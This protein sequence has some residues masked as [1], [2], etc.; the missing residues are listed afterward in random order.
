MYCLGNSGFTSTYNNQ[1]RHYCFLINQR[2]DSTIQNI[3]F[4]SL[5]LAILN[6][7][8]AN[9]CIQIYNIYS[10]P[11][12]KYNIVNYP[13]L[14]SLLQEYLQQEGEYIILRDF[15]L[16]YLLQYRVQTP[17]LH[18]VAKPL[19]NTL[20]LYDLDLVSPQGIPTWEARGFSSTTNLIFLIL[21][22]QDRLVNY[23]VYTNLDFSLDYYLITTKLLLDNIR[24][25]FQSQ[26]YQK[27]ININSI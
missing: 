4:P 26:R 11:L 20:Q 12:G 5:D 24:L 14:I 23:Q 19:L 25:L 1:W 15:N 21:S 16:Y 22:L 7:Y 9:I 18:L 27:R 10:K 3:H 13:I 2:V 6:I 17:I 8:I